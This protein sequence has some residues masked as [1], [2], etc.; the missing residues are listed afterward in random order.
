MIEIEG[1]RFAC[2]KAWVGFRC[3]AP[4]NRWE[5]A[6]VIDTEPLEDDADSPKLEVMRLRLDVAHWRE[7]AGTRLE[8]RDPTANDEHDQ[9][10]YWGPHFENVTRLE[11]AFG[12]IENGGIDVEAKGGSFRP[13][14]GTNEE[15]LIPF[16]ARARCVLVLPPAP[17]ATP[18]PPLGRKTCRACSAV[19]FEEVMRC[20]ACDAEGWWNP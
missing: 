4:G 6:L 11:L 13:V 18:A 15:T 19:S 5:M 2:S 14:L 20:P 17:Q 8:V 16:R 12:P 10:V 1:D 3:E 7:L 9:N